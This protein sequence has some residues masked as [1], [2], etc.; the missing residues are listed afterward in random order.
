MSIALVPE[1]AANLDAMRA[2]ATPRHFERQRQGSG[3]Q[4]LSGATAA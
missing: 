4:N 2:A 1:R 3:T